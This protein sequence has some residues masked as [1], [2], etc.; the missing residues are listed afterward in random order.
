[1]KRIALLVS[2]FFSATFANAADKPAVIKL[3][4]STKKRTIQALGRI[5]PNVGSMQVERADKKGRVQSV[6]VKIGQYVNVGAPLLRLSPCGEGKAECSLAATH[7]GMVS[8]ILTTPGADVD[9]GDGIVN[10]VNPKGISIRL[11]V[12]AKYVKFLSSGQRVL[13]HFAQTPG[14]KFE[15]KILEILPALGS[16]ELTR[17][18]RLEPVLPPVGTHLDT[19]VNAEISIP[20]DGTEIRVPSTA[21]G[22]YGGR[23]F[24]VKKSD[25]GFEA[26][27][28]QILSESTDSLYVR[29][30]PQAHIE[31]GEWVLS[32]GAI[33]Y[34]PRLLEEK[35]E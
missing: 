32:K 15:T 22:F 16:G 12:P 10:I 27:P 9:A 35:T 18:L 29:P 28:V 7:D 19:L 25:A 33:Y 20:T 14:K 6:A 3:E 11:D 5:M 8:E 31:S 26:V 34:L 21:V 13:V 1:M 4:F 2:I 17:G 23:H 30:A 24:L